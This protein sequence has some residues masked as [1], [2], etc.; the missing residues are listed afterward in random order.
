MEAVRGAESY[1]FSAPY[2]NYAAVH[3]AIIPFVRNVVGPAD[4][5]PVTFSDV[6]YP[7]L[8]TNAHELALCVCMA[9]RNRLMPQPYRA[10]R[11]C[12]VRCLYVVSN[13]LV[14]VTVLELDACVL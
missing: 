9:Y 2:P 13:D 12:C 6:T 1:K 7:H 5:A 4:Y 8:T 10:S 11:Q 14:K 3:N